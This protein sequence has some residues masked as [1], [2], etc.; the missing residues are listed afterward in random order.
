M[1][2]AAHVLASSTAAGAAYALTGSAAMTASC[3]LSG[4]FLDVDHLLDFW[5]L[6]GEKFT[7]GGFLSWCH[8]LRWKK[9]Y[10]LLHSYELFLLLSLSA[11]LFPGRAIEGALLG[12]GLHLLMDQAGNRGLSRWFYFM[13]FR[14]LSGFSRGA[15]AA[16]EGGRGCKS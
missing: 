11:W 12:M 14:W 6:S 7:P 8:E 10:L 2:T 4:I 3:L 15:L 1:R 5:L 9:I 13:T 16:G